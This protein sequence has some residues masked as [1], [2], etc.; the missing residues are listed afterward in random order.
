MKLYIHRV[1][2][3]CALFAAAALTAQEIDVV[4]EPEG[5]AAAQEETQESDA[6]TIVVT[7]TRSKKM[8]KD[9]PVKTQVV[10]SERIESK[11]AS[12]AF[13]ALNAE[14][15][16]VSNNGCQNCGASSVDING[17]GGNYTQVLINGYPTVSSLAGVY[18]LQQYPAELIDRIEIVRGGG[19]ALYGSGAIG[20]VVNVISR[21][22]IRNESNVTYQH[23]ILEG[24]DS[25]AQHVNAYTS[26]VTPDGKSGVAL[27]GSMLERD[28]WDANGD[29]YSDLG[30]VQNKSFGMS[31]YTGITPAMELAWNFT[32]LWEY[33]RGG[34]DID[35]PP[36]LSDIA[37]EVTTNST[38]GDVK[39][40]HDVTEDFHYSL[41]YAFA[42]ALRDTYYG[43]NSGIL[44]D[45]V[46]LYGNSESLY[47]IV[48][49]QSHWH[50]MEGHTLQAGYE[51]TIDHIEDEN[52]AT[53]NPRRIHET[54][55]N[56]GVFTQYDWDTKRLNLVG[57]VRADKHSEMDSMVLSPRASAI[58][59]FSDTFRFRGSVSFGYKA[60]QIF[61]EDFHIEVSLASTDPENKVIVNADDLEEEKSVTYAG[62]LSGEMEAGKIEMEYSLG[63]FYTEIR[64]MMAIDYSNP[65]TTTNPGTAYYTRDNESGTSRIAGSN[66][67]LN[68]YMGR[69]LSF[70]NGYTWIFMAKK[71]EKVTYANR[72]S[73]EMTEVPVLSGSSNL[74]FFYRNLSSS[75]SM[76]YLGS[77]YMPHDTGTSNLEETDPFVVLNTRVA[78]KVDIDTHRYTEF[79]VGI[80]NITNAYQDDLDKGAERDAGYVYGPIEPRTFYGGVKAG[81]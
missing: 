60:P 41:Y 62:D 56:H 27:F 65:D 45:D 26:V 81:F 66:A 55:T 34:D 25:Q 67:E 9:A 71:P 74:N 10:G 35:Q 3:V 61:D 42:R 79:F 72:S 22:P 76:Q 49:M 80:K 1:V 54:Y 21:K 29:N 38:G 2:M 24:G 39:L 33:R 13:E 43:G 23:D 20:G 8:Q 31:G 7:G 53:S 73:D 63:G 48:G 44:S 12:N 36:F 46:Q 16:I 14:S 77:M 69:M 47:Q 32:S 40:T 52:N 51:A 15:G 18:F 30:R 50:F 59:K 4:V 5:P 68:F 57:G 11:G 78:Y 6:G 75:L 28:E 70:T 17:L 64:D 58:V 19:S 37:E